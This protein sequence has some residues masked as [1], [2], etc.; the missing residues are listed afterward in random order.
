MV[1]LAANI[2]LGLWLMQSMAHVGLALAVSVSS[3]LNFVCLH[4]FLARRRGTSPVSIM[5]TAKTLLLSLCVGG[6]AYVTASWHPWWLLLI[7]VWVVIYVGMAF[8]LRMD[9]AR[10]VVELIQSR[11]RRKRRGR[12]MASVDTETILKR[13]D[14]FPRGLI[15]PEGGYRF[16][17]DSLLLA[18]LPIRAGGMSASISVAGAA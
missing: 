6:G 3:A 17:L 9:E 7:P 11:V 12:L 10:M 4:V 2:G 16:S 13:R 18:C 8:V 15:Q 1:C 5:S 14:F